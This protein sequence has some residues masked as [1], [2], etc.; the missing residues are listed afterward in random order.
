[1]DNIITLPGRPIANAVEEAVFLVFGGLQAAASAL[2]VGTPTIHATLKE[3]CVRTKVNAEKWENAT[4]AAGCTVPREEL[5]GWAPWRGVDRHPELSGGRR[6]PKGSTPPT[7]RPAPRAEGTQA[8][9][10][11]ARL[12]RQTR[13]SRGGPAWKTASAASRISAGSAERR[14]A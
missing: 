8:D 11:T 9:A 4:T 14:A 6:R 10:P 1:M 5:I 2:G 12:P 7:F 3:G 13:R